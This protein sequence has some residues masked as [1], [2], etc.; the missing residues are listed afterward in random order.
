MRNLQ[1]GTIAT[2]L[3]A[4]LA[5][6]CAHSAASYLPASG[7]YVITWSDEPE[8]T[9]VVVG[10]G[11]TR[12]LTFTGG[13]D[14]C[15]RVITWEATDRGLVEKET[16]LLLLSR[17][18]E[19]GNRWTVAAGKAGKCTVER[20]ITNVSQEGADVEEYG[21]CGGRPVDERISTRWQVGR[22]PVSEDFGG[23][24]WKTTTRL[25]AQPP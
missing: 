17:S 18:V 8:Q 14:G 15:A 5:T 20:R 9:L 2:I 13:P 21:V 7:T 22:G 3:L 12:T 4:T 23:L 6:G 24:R 16:G 11:R 1:K 10:D 25:P 19:A